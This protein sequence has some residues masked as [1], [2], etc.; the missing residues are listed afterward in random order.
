MGLKKLLTQSIIWRCFY[1]LS[2]LLVNVSL[3]RY[4]Q[5]AGTGNLYFITVIFS[6]VQGVLSLSG[7]SGLIYFASGNKIERNKLM[8]VSVLW[9]FI[10]GIISIGIVGLYFLFNKTQASFQIQW[11]CAFAFFY[12]CGQTLTNFSVGIY[13]TRENYFLP[14]LLLAFVN[15]VFVALITFNNTKPNTGSVQ[16]ITCFYFST[17]FAGGI[18]VYLSYIF[19]YKK[20]GQ[21]GF[22]ERSN[23][24]QLL[25][26][27]LTA[28]GANI[29]FFLVYKIDYLFVYYSPV[30]T[31]ADLG[32]YIQASKMGQ[33]LLLIPQIIASVVFPRTAS[34]VDATSISNA[35][36]IIARMFSQLFLLMFIVVALIGSEIFTLVFGSS[37][38]EMEIPMLILIPG[39]FSLSILVLLSAYFAGKGQVKINLYAAVVGLIIMIAGDFILVPRYGI[40]AAAAV[41]TASYMA[42]VGYSMWHFHK[43]Y[44]IHWSEFFK[45]KKTDYNT[46]FSLLK[47]NSAT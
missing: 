28:L 2:V 40:I 25:R 19:Q 38:N 47:F 12:V 6:F 3:A 44:S 20:E 21:M 9:S 11:Y 10:A 15:L 45:W 5:A 30:C 18:L 37:F 43:N 27:C 32:N 33:L 46:L 13:Y 4:L 22:P 31:P 14:N 7:E 41:S 35:I 1:F 8:T 34:G 24:I 39:I 42:N 29:I 16:W 23:F 26:Y 36:M 17:F